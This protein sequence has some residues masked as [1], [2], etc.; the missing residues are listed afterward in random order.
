MTQAAA[1]TRPTA[2]TPI[3]HIATP[4]IVH[5]MT[6]LATAPILIPQA[7]TLIHTAPIIATIRTAQATTLTAHIMTTAHTLTTTTIQVTW[8]T[9]P[10][11]TAHGRLDI[12]ITT[13]VHMLTTTAV[14]ITTMK[15]KKNNTLAST[16]AT[17][18]LSWETMIQPGI[19]S[20]LGVETGLMK[21]APS[22]LT[23]MGEILN[24]VCLFL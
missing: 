17:E 23:A 3:L 16:L 7:I 24:A 12:M 13:M 11:I 18:Q 1:A 21:L 19:K 2:T 8:I 14:K 15:K 20:T 6:I 10:M 9:L 5:I 22:M 4:I